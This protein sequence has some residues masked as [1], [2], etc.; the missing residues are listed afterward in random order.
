MFFE[1]SGWALPKNIAP[2]KQKEVI[3][4]KNKANVEKVASTKEGK[5][6][7]EADKIQAQMASLNDQPVISNKEEPSK[8]KKPRVRNKKRAL[9]EKPEVVESVKE[10]KKAKKNNKEKQQPQENNDSKKN[11]QKKKLQEVIIKEVY[12]KPTILIV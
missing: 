4:K 3:S 2:Q 6:T 9:E 10:N 8:V 12:Y 1:T 11:Q 5:A 7:Q